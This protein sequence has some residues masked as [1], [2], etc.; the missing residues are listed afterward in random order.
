MKVKICG[1][2]RAED[3]AQAEAAG[4]DAL[5][6]IFVPGSKRELELAQAAAAMADVG[7]FVT[8]VGVFR[9]Q[10]LEDVRGVARALKLSAVQLHGDEDAAFA[11]ALQKEF[12]VI[13]VWGFSSKLN[14]ETVAAFPADAVMVDG[15]K[16][17]GGETFNW[18]DAAHLRGI[19]KLILAGG[20]KPENV[21]AG[22][23]A[24]R[25]YAVD[26]ASGVEK[27]PGLKDEHKVLE[28]IRNAKATAH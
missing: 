5:G 21:T 2:T 27:S 25:P 16:P 15:I 9:N 3:A 23:E 10:A 14:R 18:A 22:I 17:G 26:V 20:L 19:P 12:T 28:F 13:K 6:F 8:R 7:P 11:R 1:I 4:A 24:L